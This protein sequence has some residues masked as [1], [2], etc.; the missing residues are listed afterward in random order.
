MDGDIRFGRFGTACRSQCDLQVAGR[1]VRKR[2]PK[3]YLIT[4]AGYLLHH[5]RKDDFSSA[6]Q[7]ACHPSTHVRE[8]PTALENSRRKRL[9]GQRIVVQIQFSQFAKTPKRPGGSEVSMLR[10]SD[11]RSKETKPAKTSSGSS[12]NALL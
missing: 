7:P 11:N 1:A 9:G 4:G 3:P 8:R 12:F 6:S 10:A 5:E 2:H